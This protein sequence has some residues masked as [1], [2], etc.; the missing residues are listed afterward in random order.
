[1][2]SEYWIT[3]K[4]LIDSLTDDFNWTK[5]KTE[6]KLKFWKILEW[7]KNATN[8]KNAGLFVNKQSGKWVSPSVVL[9]SKFIEERKYTE[10]IIE[11]L[12]IIDEMFIR[13]QNIKNF[14]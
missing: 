14:R 3:R 7:L 10:A 8:D 13:A 9:E 4:D 5:K 2:W 12:P 6:K 11:Y 1:M